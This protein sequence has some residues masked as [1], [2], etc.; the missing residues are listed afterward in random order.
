MQVRYNYTVGQIWPTGQSLTLM[1]C[2]RWLFSCETSNNSSLHV[3]RETLDHA[4]TT[5]WSSSDSDLCH[6][7]ESLNSRPPAISGDKYRSTHHF[8]TC[9]GFSLSFSISQ[10]HFNILVCSFQ[11]WD[12][13]AHNSWTLALDF[14]PL[15]APAGTT[16]IFG[17][18]GG[19]VVY[20]W[21][22]NE[23]PSTRADRLALGFSTQQKHAVLL[24]VDSASGLGDYL[25]LQIV[26]M[27][28]FP[29]SQTPTAGTIMLESCCDL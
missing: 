26:S 6:C 21:P 17:R 15:F 25:Q 4:V 9:G 13:T 3:L 2:R 29:S 18:D 27:H 16:Y 19:V 10:K 5:S 1:V 12:H 22:P 23:R 24:R 14:L 20:T 7:N 28:T 11:Q 8:P